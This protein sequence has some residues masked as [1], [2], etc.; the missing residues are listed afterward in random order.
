MLLIQQ[1]RHNY[2]TSTVSSNHQAND[3][4]P[5]KLGNLSPGGGE[6]DEEV[7]D[8]HKSPDNGDP[9]CCDY[10]YPPTKMTIQANCPV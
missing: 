3:T 1:N 6:S 9:A 8:K 2:W 10:K 5:S 4:E 7:D